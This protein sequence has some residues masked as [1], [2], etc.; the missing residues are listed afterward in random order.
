MNTTESLFTAWLAD[1][2]GVTA[3]EYGLLASLLAMAMIVGLGAFGS[4]LQAL[5]DYWIGAVRAVLSTG[6]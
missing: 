5:Y 1:G 6:A 4:S 3:I 2:S